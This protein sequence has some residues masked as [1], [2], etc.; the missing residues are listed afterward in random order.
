MISLPGLWLTTGRAADAAGI[1]RTFAASVSEGML[2]NRFPD[3]GETAEYNTID[4][5]L[6]FFRAL[7][8]YLAATND[9]ALLHD[10]WPTLVEIIAWHQRG[11]RYH[12]HVDPADG[13]L[14]CGEPG[15]QLTW[16]D[17]TVGDWAVTPRSGQ[18][19]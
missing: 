3:S 16:I 14:S 8:L 2:P 18:P 1:L 9:R 5:T 6:W 11:T 17:A 12:I 7:E 15:V 10:L 4:A 13:L 19:V